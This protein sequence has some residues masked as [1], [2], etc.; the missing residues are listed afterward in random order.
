MGTLISE[1]EARAG[2][3]SIARGRGGRRAVLTGG[4]RDG[5]VVAPAVVADVDPASPFS[6]DELF[7][8]PSR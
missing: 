4:E 3:G 8:P 2:R 1:R 6:Q 5:A 7:G